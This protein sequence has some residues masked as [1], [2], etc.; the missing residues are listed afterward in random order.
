MCCFPS[1]VVNNIFVNSTD[2][3]LKGELAL[4]AGAT[5]EL[6]YW[7]ALAYQLQYRWILFWQEKRASKKEDVNKE[8]LMY[9]VGAGE[10]ARCFW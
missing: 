10:S 5:C 1:T 2:K 4:A 3:A 9:F 8:R 7:A 6:T